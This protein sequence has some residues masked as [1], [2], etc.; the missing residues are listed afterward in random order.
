[1]GFRVP[2]QLNPDAGTTGKNLKRFKK[3][4][5]F[6]MGPPKTRGEHKSGQKGPFMMETFDEPRGYFAAPGLVRS[7]ILGNGNRPV[8]EDI[9]ITP[10]FIVVPA[11]YDGL[12]YGY[13]D[14]N[15]L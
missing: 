8:S 14:K 7:H 3:Q 12:G 6:L 10:F 13:S 11:V 15:V 5:I 4:Q 2:K 9:D 1:M